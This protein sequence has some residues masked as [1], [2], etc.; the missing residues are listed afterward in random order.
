MKVRVVGPYQVAHGKKVHAPGEEFDAPDVDAQQWLARGYV[1]EV[2]DAEPVKA[3]EPKAEA[4]PKAQSRSE[5]KAQPSAQN[6][7]AS[8]D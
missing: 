2:S 1:A 5:N 7:A 3:E 8:S 6:K 4:K